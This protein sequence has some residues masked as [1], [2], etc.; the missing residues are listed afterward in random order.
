MGGEVADEVKF[1]I[2]DSCLGKP[3]TA[4]VVFH[5][6]GGL[7]RRRA[8][9]HLEA[10]KDQ[11]FTSCPP[12]LHVRLKHIAQDRPLVYQES[13]TIEHLEQLSVTDATDVNETFLS[14]LAHA[15]GLER[16]QIMILAPSFEHQCPLELDNTILKWP[17]ASLS[18]SSLRG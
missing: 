17:E 6:V 9:P 11:M 12:V 14:Q 2:G 15:G 5:S 18:H 4:G 13:S 10:F 1:Y 8:L 16:F 7:I 3:G